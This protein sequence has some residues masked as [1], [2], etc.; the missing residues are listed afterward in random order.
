MPLG[1][2]PTIPKADHDAAVAE[3][4]R[5][6]RS[7]E[8]QL[9]RLVAADRDRTQAHAALVRALESQIER[10]ATRADRSDARVESLVRDYAELKRHEIGALPKGA[11]EQ[12]LTD[13]LAGL[14]EK[15]RMAIEA[16]SSGDQELYRHLVTQAKLHT[17]QLQMEHDDA[18]ALDGAVAALI[19]A[20]DTP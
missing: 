3:L 9:T 13:P 17:S 10:E 19:L 15:T 7:L 16:F 1:R 8:D 12:S 20:G 18:A 2:A 4:R 5:T 11:Y 14:G 6:I